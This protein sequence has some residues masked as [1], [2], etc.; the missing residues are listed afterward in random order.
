MN[1]EYELLKE[2]V[3]A[4]RFVM[5]KYNALFKAYQRAKEYI[6]KKEKTKGKE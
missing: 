5:P 4:V 6:E 3:E 1:K 2:L